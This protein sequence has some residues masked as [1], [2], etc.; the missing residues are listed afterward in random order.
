M[1][2]R[3]FVVVPFLNEAAGIG[4]TLDALAAQSVQDFALVFVDNGSSDCTRRLIEDFALRHR[5][6]T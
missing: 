3:L 5:R 4:P 2:D 6:S 1:G